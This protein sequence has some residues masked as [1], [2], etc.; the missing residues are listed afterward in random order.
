MKEH[1][2]IVTFIAIQV[3]GTSNNYQIKKYNTKS[4]F[5]IIFLLLHNYY[6]IFIVFCFIIIFAIDKEHTC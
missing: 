1:Q 5:I 4:E 6:F 3:Q 2:E